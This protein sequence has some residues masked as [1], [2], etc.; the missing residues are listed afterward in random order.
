MS[1]Q[2]LQDCYTDATRKDGLIAF[3]QKIRTPKNDLSGKYSVKQK[4]LDKLFSEN[5]WVDL[6]KVGGHRKLQNKVTGVII[7]YAA[8]GNKGGIDP[9]AALTILDAVQNHLN[10]LGNDVFK[11]EKC[12]WKKEPDYQASVR[13]LEDLQKNG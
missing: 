12:N 8:H 6:K 2:A 13:R 11:Y 7:E 5:V 1:I 10:I 4:D 9:G 3:T